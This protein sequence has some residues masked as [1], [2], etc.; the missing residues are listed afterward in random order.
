E[1]QEQAR[2]EIDARLAAAVAGDPAGLKNID[3]RIAELRKPLQGFRAEVR[4]QINSV[5]AAKVAS[6]RAEAERAISGALNLV[7]YDTV[8]RIARKVEERAVGADDPFQGQIG[9]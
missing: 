2:R 4:R 8:D 9:R 5:A 7:R 3:A 6:F 1:A